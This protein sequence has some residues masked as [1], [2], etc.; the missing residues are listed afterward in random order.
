MPP[1]YGIPS[2]PEVAIQGKDIRMV[3]EGGYSVAPPRTLQRSPTA[4]RGNL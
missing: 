1:P 2:A 3:S 4:E